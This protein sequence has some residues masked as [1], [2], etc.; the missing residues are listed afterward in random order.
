MSRDKMTMCID[1]CSRPK[2]KVLILTKNVVS[3]KSTYWRG[4]YHILKTL[5]INTVCISRIG[6]TD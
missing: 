6:K 2:N 5:L 3:D 1:F 4:V